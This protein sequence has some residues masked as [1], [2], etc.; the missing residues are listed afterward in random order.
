M[1]NQEVIHLPQDSGKLPHNKKKV[2]AVIGGIA[3][4]LL[5]AIIIKFTKT[6]HKIVLDRDTSKVMI[7]EDGNGHFVL[8]NGKP[9]EIKGEFSKGMITSDRKHV[10]LLDKDGTL[11]AYDA[12]GENK[13]TIYDEITDIDRVTNEGII[14]SNK[15]VKGDT[16]EEILQA[17]VDEWV[18]DNGKTTT[19]AIVKYVYNKQ[20]SYESTYNAKKMYQALMNK[21]YETTKEI[22]SYRYLFSNQKTTELGEGKTHIATNSL[23]VIVSTEEGIYVLKENEEKPVK[24]IE[25]NE[26]ALYAVGVSDSG[27]S[28]VWGEETDDG[29]QLKAKIYGEDTNLYKIQTADLTKNSYTGE[30][31][32]LAYS[33]VREVNDGKDFLFLASNSDQILLKK[34]GKEAEYVKFSGTVKGFYSKDC[35][36]FDSENEVEIDDFY[37]VIAEEDSSSTLYHIGK[38]GDKEKLL[39]NIDKLNALKA[40]RIYY[41]DMDKNLMVGTLTEKEVA[42]PV[43]I[44][45]EVTKAFLAPQG[46]YIYYLKNYDTTTYE[47]SLYVAECDNKK[48]EYE[49]E[50]IASDV[51]EVYLTADGETVYY[52]KDT[53]KTDAILT[54]TG[55]LY[56]K[57]MKR[58]PE[59]ITSDVSGLLS[60]YMCDYVVGER[61][62]FKKVT[63]VKDYK[64]ISDYKYFNGNDAESIAQGIIN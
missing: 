22:T 49:G 50:K 14:F 2:I 6:D 63:E 20:Y 8:E 33:H 28:F 48:K 10:I 9:I 36:S 12:D 58:E 53:E 61:F 7:D 35:N 11:F 60:P 39:S 37:V 21:E 47:G 1:E 59:K 51:N 17:I 41:I 24:V 23:S 13:D 27:N 34:K 3:V 29:I 54:R 32:K 57:A 30:Y 64:A 16:F 31:D 25:K 44:S 4:I 18:D 5:V 26:K 45:K 46:D 52:I 19:Y 38:S 43:K 15:I 40:G 62:T 42:D 56:S 55:Q